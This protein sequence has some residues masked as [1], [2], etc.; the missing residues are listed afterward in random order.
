MGEL[1]VGARGAE[2]IAR[3]ARDLRRLRAETMRRRLY[4]A[5]NRSTRP[6]I[7]AAK[8]SALATL[9][10][11]GG[12][13]ARTRLRRTGTKTIGGVDYVTRRRVRIAGSK[14]GDSLAS[15]AAG[16]RYSTKILGG[17]N[18]TVRVIATSGRKRLDLEKAD[19]GTVRHP[20]YGNR[21]VWVA[22][23]VTPK[24]FT[25]PMEQ[26][27][28]VVERELQQEVDAIERDLQA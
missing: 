1:E 28:P 11:T 23:A 20:V 5:L 14:R 22:Q 27:A 24:W 21:R 4:A 8:A 10:S 17:A 16:A 18:P 9:P 3:L 19:D 6:A 26:N 13:V 15:R 25:R 7:E 12:T 2:D